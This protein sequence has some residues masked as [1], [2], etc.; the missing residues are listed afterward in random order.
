MSNSITT[1][2]I[3]N[4][5]SKIGYDTYSISL[6]P[7]INDENKR[8]EKITENMKLLTIL[9]QKNLL[10]KLNQSNND[11]FRRENEELKRKNAELRKQL[12]HKSMECEDLA[13][14]YMRKHNQNETTSVRNLY[15]K[16]QIIYLK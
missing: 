13:G 14:K 9:E 16:S 2:K 3:E 11:K 6:I 15:Y 7:D 10:F 12:E 8:D 1:N 5:L 4:N